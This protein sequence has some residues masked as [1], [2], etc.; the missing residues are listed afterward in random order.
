MSLSEFDRK[1]LD[2]CLSRSPR[3]WEDFVDRFLGLVLHVVTHTAQSRSLRLRTEDRDDLV[4]EVF[5]A[6]VKDD[7]ALLKRF[8]GQS[9]L[10]TYLTVVARRV[11]VHGLLK[12][13]T[14]TSLND[15]TEKSALEKSAIDDAKVSTGP[16]QQVAN[17]DEVER[18]LGILHGPEA[19]VVRMYHL[20]GKSY[21]EISKDTGIPENSIGPTL[22][23]AR[24]KMRQQDATS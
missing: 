4:A 16:E 23:R 6:I 19:Q 13:K 12:R 14:V 18:L 11:A 1:L 2:R 3:S 10:A 22:S 17:H 15:L 5:L 8:R 21:R 24:N 9:S 7:L 20:E